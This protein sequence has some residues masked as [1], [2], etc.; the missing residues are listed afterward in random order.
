MALHQAAVLQQSVF[1]AE[2]FVESHQEP[3][4]DVLLHQMGRPALFR[5]LELPVA[6]PDGAAVLAVGVP[7]LGAVEGAAVA[8][9]DAGGKNAPSAVAVAQPLPPSELG[10]HS[11]ELVRVDD[12]LVAFLNV[13]LRNLA[14]VDLHLLLQKIHRELLLQERRPFVLL[15]REDGGHRGRSPFALSR[16]GGDALRCEGLG[17]EIGSFPRHEKAVNPPNNGGLLLNDDRDVI[18]SLFVAEELLVRQAD[19]S[20]GEPLSLAP[21]DVLRNGAALLL[22]QRGHDG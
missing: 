20:I 6:L 13:I 5:A 11:V 16:R 3:G 22:G 21:G 10:L 14:L 12:G 4:L 8:A 19:L 1:A 2:Q 18:R 7:H 15:I 9:D 17:D